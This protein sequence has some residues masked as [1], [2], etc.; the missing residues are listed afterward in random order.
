MKNATPAEPEGCKRW[1]PAINA[2]VVAFVL[3]VPPLFLL[4]GGRNGERP[5]VWIKTAVAGLR[6]GCPAEVSLLNENAG[7]HADK[8]LGGL[9]VEGFDQESC[10]SRYQSAAY[11]RNTGRQPSQHLVSKLRSHEALQRRCGPGTAAYTNALEQLKSGKSVASPECR[12]LVSIS[13]RG[14]GNRIIAAASAFLYAVLTDR[15]FLVDPSNGM[16]ELFCEPFPN[17]TWLL[18]PGFPLV[19]YQGFYLSTPERYGRMRE[20]GVLRTGEVNGS[21]A[22]ELPAFAYI[23]L[24][25][26]QTDHDKLF[27]CDDDQRLM[28]NIQW[29]VMR[30]DGYIA[31][32]LFLVRAFQ[33]KL[34]A[35]FPERD[36]VFHHL[37]RYLFHPT[38]RVWGLITRYYD[39]H[40][41]RARR[42]VGIQVRVF[43]WQADSPELLEQI[44]TCTQNQKLLPAVLGE[45]DDE[46]AAAPGGAAKP[47]AVLITSL[48]AWYYDKMKGAY[49]ERATANGEV[50]VVDQPSHEETQR[51]H[52]RSHE[53]KAWAEVYLLS[54][55]DTL[56][57]TA[58][59]TFGYVAQGLGGM[60]PWVLRM[61]MINTTVSWPC[62][63][64]MSME[65]C[66]H[67]PPVYDCKRR[68]DAGKIVPHV[69]HCKD[70]PTG[71]K[72]VDPKD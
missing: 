2:V 14:L 63:R 38:N 72:L 53:R 64:D 47:T 48:K 29:L 11:R 51:Y 56:V 7:A 45:E 68:Q 20:D 31:P 9:L 15:V 41:A 23:H 26:N 37:G 13:Y 12:Y 1:A 17:T 66:Y 58:E 50:V 42:V 62:S 30:T 54:T 22:A 18:P 36:A 65:P 44:K 3:I 59:S 4:L 60:R 6:R 34:D 24:D 52:V 21:A 69:R 5:A 10:R 16:D 57:T 35:L 71:L 19:S 25:H 33:G 27:F 70:W 39:A 55:A 46:P 8:L 61:G 49:W 40:F 43:P 32:G 67:V 28:S